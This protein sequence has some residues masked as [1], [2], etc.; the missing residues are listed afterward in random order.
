VSIQSSWIG[1]D[2]RPTSE[3]ELVCLGLERSIAPLGRG[4]ENVEAM[5]TRLASSPP[6]L[7]R[8]SDAPLAGVN[9]EDSPLGFD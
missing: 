8:S 4:V 2:P 3:V 5:P 6:L 9:D 1:P 7:L